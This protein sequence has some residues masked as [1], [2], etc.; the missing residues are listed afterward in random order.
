MSTASLLPSAYQLFFGES[1][2]APR[3]V[4]HPVEDYAAVLSPSQVRCLMDCSAR[5]KYKYMLGMPEPPNANLSLGTAVHEA[6]AFNFRQ[7]METR[8]D[9][10]VSEVVT[11][12][13][14]AWNRIALETEFRDEENPKELET[15]GRQMTELYMRQA[16]PGIM[17]AAVEVQVE[18]TIAGVKVQGKVDIVEESGRI[19]DIKTSSRRSSC[20]SNEQKFQLASYAPFVPN[21]TGEVVIDQLVKTKVPAYVQITH[22]VTRQD[23]AATEQMYPAAQAFARAGMYL[24]NRTSNLCSRKGCAF[25]RQCVSEFGGDVE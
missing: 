16:A 6:L 24:P 8:Q 21:A 15:Q 12:F 20:I 19:R 10:S 18:G 25:W 1:F 9:A 2:T 14:R 11:E 17:P 22:T 13:S 3:R 7:K 5:W 23:R 4:A